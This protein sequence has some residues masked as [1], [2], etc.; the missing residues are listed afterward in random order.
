MVVVV[1]AS[2]DEN[3]ESFDDKR[4]IG[5]SLARHVDCHEEYDDFARLTASHVARAGGRLEQHPTNRRCLPPC[6]V[7]T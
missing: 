1:V 2:A 6:T 7:L 5:P 3:L 4:P